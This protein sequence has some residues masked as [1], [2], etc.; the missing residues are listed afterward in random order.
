MQNDVFNEIVQCGNAPVRICIEAN[1]G[2]AYKYA[3]DIL[4]KAYGFDGD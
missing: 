3:T 2:S 4:R 1:E